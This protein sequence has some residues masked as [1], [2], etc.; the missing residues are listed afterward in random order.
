MSL[1]VLLAA[2]ALTADLSASANADD[3]PPQPGR[4]LTL[5]EALRLAREGSR[6]LGAARARLEQAAVGIAQAWVALLPQ[7]AVQGKYTHNYKEV[8]LDLA[9]QNQ[10]LFRL[11]DVLK[12]NTQDRV[13]YGALDLYERQAAAASSGP[14]IVIQKQEQL[15][16]V[17]QVTV[18]VVVPWAYSNLTAARR[19]VAAARADFET[20][21]ATI[22]L[23]A[24][25]AFFTAAGADAILLARRHAVAVATRTLQD[26]RVRL[27]AGVVHRVEVTRAE[28]ALLRA[29][30]AARE[31]SD[32][33]AQAY[34][35]L[36]TLIQLDE[37]FHVV[38]GEA[39]PAAPPAEALV[40]EAMQ[41]RPELSMLL[42]SLDATEAQVES[43]QWRWAPTLSAFANVRAFNYAGFS[44][45][46]Y[47]WAVGAQLD[48]VLYDGGLRDAQTQLG[49]AQRREVGLRLA[50]L[51]DTVRDEV[52]VAR[53]SLDTKRRARDTAQRSVSLTE[54]TLELVRAQYDA[55][56]AT[57]LDL[58]QAQDAL[59]AAEVA[60]AQARFDL[61]LSDLSLRRAVGTFPGPL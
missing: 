32:S 3:R 52:F 42:R 39:M 4:A 53:R 60:L 13:Q 35:S 1:T 18:P 12:A 11:V 2:L 46:H 54:D 14:P 51:C 28:L 15:D 17:G 6:D 8:T 48:W 49:V 21:Q 20:T 40:A 31:A 23:T 41:L 50:Q 36:A 22:L 10:A 37:A 33:E 26:A 9:Q 58:L 44:G 7:V 43:A 38:P 47:A 34:R 5:D 56:S 16:L 61:A 59:V 45:D 30:Q 29:E 25:Q 27:D 19:T 55:G 57:Q 24:A